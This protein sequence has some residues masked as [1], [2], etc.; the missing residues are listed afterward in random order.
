[1]R[2]TTVIIAACFASGCSG[3]PA[4]PTR[5]DGLYSGASAVYEEVMLEIDRTEDHVTGTLRLRSSEG[6][7]VFD[8][9]VSGT[10]WSPT[11]FVMHGT[12]M[13]AGEPRELELQG[14]VVAQGLAISILSDWLEQDTVVLQPA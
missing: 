13:V 5:I 4:D 14:T 9:P 12:A 10:F 7:V 3:D 2:G 8:G 1:M 6:D 11:Q